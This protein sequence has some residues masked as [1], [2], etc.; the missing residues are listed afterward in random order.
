METY[1][2]TVHIIN[3]KKQMFSRGVFITQLN[4]SDGVF[5][6]NRKQVLAASYF[7]KKKAIIDMRLDS[8]YDCFLSS[9]V[10]QNPFHQ[11]FSADERKQFHFIKREK[12]SFFI[13]YSTNRNRLS[14]P[15]KSKRKL[16]VTTLSDWNL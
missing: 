13:S 7:R 4:V 5:C 11:F 10:P 1:F 2:E 8:K 9:S 16:F 3:N 15:S 14:N 6:E 12:V